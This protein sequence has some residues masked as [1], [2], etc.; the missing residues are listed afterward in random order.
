M[1][2]PASSMVPVAHAFRMGPLTVGPELEH[3]EAVGRTGADAGVIFYAARILDATIAHAT[4]AAGLEPEPNLFSNLATLEGLNLVDREVACMANAVRRLGNAVRHNQRWIHAQDAL[5]AKGM[6]APCLAW[7]FCRYPAG[8]RLPRLWLEGP[9]QLV[10]AL[11]P[12]S[13]ATPLFPG[14][15]AERRLAEGALEEAQRI[16]EHGLELYP[17][18]LRLWQLLALCWSRKGFPERAVAILEP[19]EQR[20]PDDESAGILAGACK[21]LWLEDRSQTHWLEQ[22]HTRY[23][24][25]WRRSRGNAYLGINAATTALWLGRDQTARAG[26]EAV[27]KTLLTREQALRRAPLAWS[28]RMGFWDQV[29]LAESELILGLFGSAQCRYA[30]AFAT[31]GHG[32]SGLWRVARQQAEIIMACMGVPEALEQLDR[33]PA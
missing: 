24:Q 28:V 2:C 6:L 17:D 19:L 31:E 11:D 12:N 13:M 30:K 7:F 14:L 8:P 25:Q 9:S 23:D 27:R 16:L 33:S 15:A 22:A 3:M 18:D 10:P 32:D 1:P 21:R 29:T 5:A 26:A 4:E 20:R